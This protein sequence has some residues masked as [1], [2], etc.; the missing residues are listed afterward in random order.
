[1]VPRV[2]VIERFHCISMVLVFI[3]PERGNSLVGVGN[4]RA[5][6]PINYCSFSYYYILVQIASVFAYS[7]D[8]RDIVLA[9]N[10]NTLSQ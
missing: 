1:M 10:D 8:A 5:P 3:N 9:K 4:P 2:S 7:D 6:R